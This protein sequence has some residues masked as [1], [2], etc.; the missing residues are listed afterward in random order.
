[1]HTYNL[2]QKGSQGDSMTVVYKYMKDNHEEEGE[3]MFS[4]TKND[5]TR[6]NRCQLK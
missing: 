6:N 4:L 1:M 5:K 2:E 3:G